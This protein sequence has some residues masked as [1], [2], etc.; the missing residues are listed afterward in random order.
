MKLI[1]ITLFLA[2]S[3]SMCEKSS[4]D[5]LGGSQ[6]LNGRVLL[7]DTINGSFSARAVS[8]IEVFLAD[9]KDTTSFLSSVRTDKNG[10]YSFQGTDP[11]VSYKVYTAADTGSV[12]YYGELRYE[13]GQVRQ[14]VSQDLMLY[15]AVATQNGIHV[16]VQ[17]RNGARLSGV[18]VRGYSSRDFFKAGGEGQTFDLVTSASGIA[19]K[20]NLAAQKYYLLVK[21][22]VA[23]IDMAGADSVTVSPAGIRTVVLTTTAVLP[24]RNGMEILITDPDGAPVQGAGVFAYRSRTVFNLDTGGANSLFTMSSDRSGKAEAFDVDSALYYIRAVKIVGKDTLFGTDTVS[25]GRTG[26]AKR[27]FSLH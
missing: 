11:A 22:R 15:P 16:I 13:S 23:G 14:A 24:K 21:T 6:T 4:F 17:D 2:A 1:A 18:T 26:I 3:M 7:K 25:V 19:N 20:M 12:R 5:D 27:Q 9:L 10:S 8:S